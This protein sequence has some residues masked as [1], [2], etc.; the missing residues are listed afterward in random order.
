MTSAKFR[1]M[2]AGRGSPETTFATHGEIHKAP[3]TKV[4]RDRKYQPPP[5][6][7]VLPYDDERIRGITA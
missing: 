7:T 4:G 2:N 3:H 5:R 1:R 6:R